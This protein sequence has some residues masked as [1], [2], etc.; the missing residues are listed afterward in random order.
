[1]QVG[2]E[3]G[4]VGIRTRD[5]QPAEAEAIGRALDRGPATCRDELLDLRLGVA[6]RTALGR[7]V[8][9]AADAGRR[10]AFVPSES[11]ACGTAN[12]A[13]RSA[14]GGL[15]RPRI[16]SKRPTRQPFSDSSAPI[17]ARLS[18]RC[19]SGGWVDMSAPIDSR[20]IAG[21]K[22]NALIA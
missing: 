9:N 1:M 21:A 8:A 15:L 2:D 14:S 6:E 7:A 12:S 16:E 13:L 5:G 17:L 18:R 11:A 22:K 10:E 19:C 4:D 3:S 20:L